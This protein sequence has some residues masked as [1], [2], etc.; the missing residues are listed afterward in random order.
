ERVRVVGGVPVNLCGTTSPC[1]IFDKGGN[2]LSLQIVRAGNFKTK[3]L[4]RTQIGPK[5]FY[6]GNFRGFNSV[7]W[8]DDGVTYCL[9]SD[10]NKNDVLNFAATLISR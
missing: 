10:I 7:L 9:T 3:N 4:E 6:L 8:I 5:E 2:K 1:V